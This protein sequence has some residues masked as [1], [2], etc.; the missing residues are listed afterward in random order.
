ML[1]KLLVEKSRSFVYEIYFG[2]FR[3]ARQVRARCVGRKS[4]SYRIVFRRQLPQRVRFPEQAHREMR[5]QTQKPAKKRD[6]FQEA[7]PVPREYY[8]QFECY[9]KSVDSY[10]SEFLKFSVK[11]QRLPLFVLNIIVLAL[12]LAF[13]GLNV[14]YGGNLLIILAPVGLAV[15]FVL[16]SVGVRFIRKGNRAKAQKVFFNFCKLLD[17]YYGKDFFLDAALPDEVR[18]DKVDRAVSKIDFLTRNG[19]DKDMARKLA[20]LLDDEELKHPRTVEQQKKLNAAL[21]RLVQNL[22]SK[23]EKLA[24]QS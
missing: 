1:E 7:S 5:A 13:A 20:R 14:F 21:N 23:N 10:P 15:L 9:K 11:K 4:F 17:F 18:N 8:S 3:A 2:Q 6:V 16:L 12:L 24:A 19:L 22:S